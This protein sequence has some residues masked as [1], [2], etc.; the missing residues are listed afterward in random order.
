MIKG[1]EDGKTY[2]EKNVTRLEAYIM[3]SRAFGELDAPKG[4]NLR[5]G[6]FDLIFNDVPRWAEKELNIISESG[7]LTETDK[8]IL[9]TNDN[10]SKDELQKMIDRMYTYIGTLE[11]D[12]FYST[13]NKT[14]LDNSTIDTGYTSNSTFDELIKINEGQVQNII[15]NAVESSAAMGTNEQ[16]IADF[17][18]TALDI[19]T[20]NKQG[21]KPIQ[22]YLDLIDDAQNMNQLLEVDA[23]LD[24]ETGRCFLIP[25]SVSADAKDST[26]NILNYYGAITS[27]D[28]ESYKDSDSKICSAFKTMITKYLIVGGETE[29][30]AEKLA[31]D[32]FALERDLSNYNLN[33]QQLYDVDKTY[34]MYTKIDFIKMFRGFD[35][36]VTLRNFGIDQTDDINVI[37]VDLTKRAAELM[38]DSNLHTWKAKLKFALIY[39]FSGILSEDIEKSVNEFNQ[40]YTGVSGDL[41]YKEKALKR[42]SNYM[43]TPIEQIYAKTYFSET[44]KK[45]VELM[46]KQFI[47]V[48]KEKIQKNEWL[49]EETKKMAIKKLETMRVKI[50]YP[51]VWPE[52]IDQVQII[53]SKDGGNLFN[54][55]ASIENASNQY[56]KKCIG[57]PVDKNEWG[58]NV[59]EVNAYYN[60][61][62]NEIVFPA[63]ILQPPFYDEKGSK[64]ANLG[65]I[66]M[67]IAHEITHAFDNNGAAYDENGNV[68]NWWTDD[69]FTN[70]NK[71]CTQIINLYDG[72][73]VAPG[74]E[75]NGEFTVSENVADL[76]GLS[77][78]IEVASNLKNPDYKALFNNFAVAFRTTRGRTTLDYYTRVDVHSNAMLRVNQT[79]KKFDEFYETYNVSEGDGMY[80]APED[81]VI[82]W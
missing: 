66:G 69:D 3:I 27:L 62:G 36:A 7:L 57:Q 32:V 82:I 35:M 42:T 43:N 72:V 79:V 14:W 53:S 61:S 77:C 34:N 46:I 18:V 67:I 78:A 19:E 30:N 74:V 54:N 22:K 17:Y 44:A 15:D 70:F 58:L 63:G 12:N 38:T 73:E 13:V 49:S 10:I 52:Y 65:A 26:R 48:Y 68:N 11:V 2:K 45:D 24:N 21:I 51:D 16:K 59:Y 23:M 28:K 76:G 29:E 8:G 47:K 25:W 5:S 31:Q 50:G 9:G 41:S 55:I 40:V 71:K 75:N 4:H 60:P 33:K 39:C 80:L 81:R 37:K 56:S 1:Y 20:R 64:E 6:A